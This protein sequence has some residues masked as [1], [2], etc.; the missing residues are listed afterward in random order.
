[1]H[2][3]RA[4]IFAVV[5]EH[6]PG[7]RSAERVCV[8]QNGFEH[9]G[10]IAWRGVDDAENFG[11]CGLLFERLPRLGQEPRVLDSDYR[12]VRKRGDKFDLPFRKRLNPAAA[13]R[14]NPYWLAFA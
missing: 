10:E 8:V 3:D 13:E 11:G 5:Q 6:R 2:R 9:R 14:E 7:V 1:M 12:L 4:E